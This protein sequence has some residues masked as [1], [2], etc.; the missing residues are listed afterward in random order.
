MGKLLC[1]YCTS[2]WTTSTPSADTQYCRSCGKHFYVHPDGKPQHIEEKDKI[3][4]HHCGSNKIL[5]NG[6]YHCLDCAKEFSADIPKELEV[7]EDWYKTL[8]D[9]LA[10][11]HRDGGQHSAEVGIMQS[12]EDA[13]KY[14]YFRLEERL[15]NLGTEDRLCPDCGVRQT[16]RSFGKWQHLTDDGYLGSFECK[17]KPEVKCPKCGCETEYHQTLPSGKVWRCKS[18]FCGYIFQEKEKTVDVPKVKCPKCGLSLEKRSSGVHFLC[19]SCNRMFT[20]DYLDKISKQSVDVPIDLSDEDF[21]T[22]AKIAH[23]QDLT[24]N[25][26]VCN[27]LKEQMEKEEK[28]VDTAIETLIAIIRANDCSIEECR[29]VVNNLINSRVKKSQEKE[30][31]SW[32]QYA[33]VLREEWGNSERGLSYVN[34]LER[35]LYDN[36][37]PVRG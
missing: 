3:H 17:K 34:W 21:T 20:K 19:S 6:W 11:I 36:D 25:Q 23:E 15:K 4:C 7:K 33:D 10:V 14:F 22:L 30:E 26:L 9:L 37:V 13:K 32:I 31:K 29:E 27:I 1:P 8:L 28:E 35:K 18:N 5:L 24:F 16:L 12:I 2:S